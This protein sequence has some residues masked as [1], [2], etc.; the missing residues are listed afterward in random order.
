[1][2]PTVSAARYLP[3]RPFP[4]ADRRPVPL[5]ARS[6]G[7][8][9]GHAEDGLTIGEQALG[10]VPADAVAALDCPHPVGVLTAGG[11]C[12]PAFATRA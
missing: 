12:W 3:A 7:Q 2:W 11:Q 8:L 6:N 10:D 1:M 4:V 5:S 9:R